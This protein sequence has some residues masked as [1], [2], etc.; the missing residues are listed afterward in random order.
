MTSLLIPVRWNGSGLIHVTAHINQLPYF[1]PSS[2]RAKR[3]AGPAEVTAAFSCMLLVM[4]GG[5][6]RDPEDQVKDSATRPR[7]R[8]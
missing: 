4:G 6:I 2:R 7:P 8:V 1:G 5:R 3:A